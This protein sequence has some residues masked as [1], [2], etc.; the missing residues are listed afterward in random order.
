MRKHYSP[1]LQAKVVLEMLQETQPVTEIA[2]EY[3]IAP[4]ILHRW[5]REVVDRLPDLFADPA[6]G[7]REAATQDVKV[8]LSPRRLA[9]WSS[10]GVMRSLATAP[11]ALT[12]LAHDCPQQ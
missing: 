8:P 7:Q 4:R 3:G 10:L 9:G 1:T 12:K 11:T 6:A 5:R 2:T